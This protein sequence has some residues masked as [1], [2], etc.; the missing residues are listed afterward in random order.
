MKAHISFQFQING[1]FSWGSFFFESKNY[2][3]ISRPF[4]EEAYKWA[5]ENINPKGVIFIGIIKLE[6]EPTHDR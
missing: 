5:K 2:K 3:S 4:V 1:G 6:D